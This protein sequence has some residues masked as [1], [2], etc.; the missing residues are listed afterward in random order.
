[1]M[2][3]IPLFYT[4]CWFTLAVAMQ[5]DTVTLVQS[6][7]T[8]E[9]EFGYFPGPHTACKPFTSVTISNDHLYTRLLG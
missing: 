1:M 3:F 6:L 2:K 5:M 8:F 7:E 4:S 9:L